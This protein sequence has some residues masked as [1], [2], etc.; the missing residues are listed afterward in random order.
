MKVLHISLARVKEYTNPEQWL[1]H[2]DFFT[3]SLEEMASLG[4]RVDSIHLISYQGTLTRNGVNYHFLPLKHNSSPQLWQYAKRLAPD[5]VIMH[6]LIFPLQSLLLA[7]FLPRSIKI[8]MQHHAERPLRFPKSVLQKVLDR[9]KVSAYL[10][11]ANDLAQPWIKAG[12]VARAD[13]VYD[14]MEVSSRFTPA[15]EPERN[16]HANSYTYLWVGRLDDN[17]DPLTLVKAFASFVKERR[18]HKLYIVFRGGKLLNEVQSMVSQ[19]DSASIVIVG[20]VA[21]DQLQ[22]WYR[23]S[24]FIV[25]TSHYEGSGTAVCEGISCGCIPI[26]IDMPSF[27]MMTNEGDVGI[28][29]NPGK[30][31][32]L[33]QA[34]T[35]STEMNVSLEKQRVL[36]L[37]QAKLSFK[38]IAR[39]TLNIFKKL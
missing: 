6:G 23:K 3:G 4:C 28:L 9:T 14:V 22:D 24:D 8:V 13:K 30:A 35:N 17:K 21:H 15:V 12:Q 26:M 19:E 20:E 25:S 5:I 32:S 27:R 11:S 18:G 7:S 36:E 33:H 39:D 38:A 1:Q 29:F 31:G 2:I 37:F 16:R 34:L 10:F